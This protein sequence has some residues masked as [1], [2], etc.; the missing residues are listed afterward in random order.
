MSRRQGIFWLLT[1]PHHDFT[2]FLP[3]GCQFI[4][5]QL[6]QG[7]GT[8]YLHWQVLVAFSRKQSLAG[9]KSVFGSSVHA[10][11]SRSDAAAKYVQ[12]EETRIEGTQ[13][14][15]GAKPFSRNSSVEWESVWTAA[16][17]GNLEQIPANVRVV[18]YRTIRA[19]GADYSRCVG[20]EREC[21]VYWGKTGT[22]KSRRAWDEAGLEAYC[23]D[24]RS[25]FWDGYQLQEHVVIDEFRGGIDIAHLLRWLDRYPVRVE[26]K[27]SSKPLLA[28]KVWITSNLR[29]SNWYPDVDPDTVDALMR[30]LTVEELE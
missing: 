1:I 20:M 11:L 7:E 3:V 10:E 17:S 29:P 9:V 28:K 30:R 25:K 12:K 6:E 4:V 24:P 16:Q 27:G 19:I 26:I 23:K 15:L 21:H 22:G 2:P 13:F 18:N 8:G 14:E 5:G